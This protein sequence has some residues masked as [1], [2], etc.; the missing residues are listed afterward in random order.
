MDFSYL[1][2]QEK[3][4]PKIDIKIPSVGEVFKSENLYADM[5]NTDP[6]FRIGN[7]DQINPNARTLNDLTLDAK[8][9]YLEKM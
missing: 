7:V 8:T 6:A 4:V 3:R 2:G 5:S 9:S 1:K